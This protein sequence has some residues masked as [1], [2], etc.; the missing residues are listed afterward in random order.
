MVRMLCTRSASLMKMTRRSRAIDSSILRKFSACADWRLSKC[1]PASLVTPSTSPATSR[2]KRFSTS[3]AVTGVSSTTS[4][5][6]AAHTQRGL[7]PRLEQVEQDQAHLDQVR[8][9]GLAR[10][11]ALPGVRLGGEV[12]ARRHPVAI[13]LG[14][15]L[16]ERGD[17]RGAQ[18]GMC[19]ACRALDQGS[20][21]PLTLS[22]MRVSPIHSLRVGL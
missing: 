6:S 7:D 14:G 11:A 19:S 12:E 10:H 15:A 13:G 4:C 9:V 5:S 21:T 8:D 18:L 16:V 17:Q 1:S 3:S 20:F 22:C 2:P